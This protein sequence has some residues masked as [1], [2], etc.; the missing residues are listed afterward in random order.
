MGFGGEGYIACIENRF[1]SAEPDNRTGK[2]GV[3]HGRVGGLQ[4]AVQR[5][6]PDV[7][8][9]IDIRDS[10]AFHFVGFGIPDDDIDEFQRRIGT[11]FDDSSGK[12]AVLGV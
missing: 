5:Q 4:G 11:F 8:S 12:P 1:G 9:A 3:A 2:R 7:E 10:P 6:I